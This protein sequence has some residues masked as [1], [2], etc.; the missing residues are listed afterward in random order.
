M[1]MESLMMWG[2]GIATLV[3][4]LLL[5]SATRTLMASLLTALGAPIANLIVWIIRTLWKAHLDLI[6]S[7]VLSKQRLF[8][9][10]KEKLQDQEDEQRQRHRKKST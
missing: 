2:V 7:L 5:M 6:F 1:E 8:N 3:V 9:S 4:I 10:L